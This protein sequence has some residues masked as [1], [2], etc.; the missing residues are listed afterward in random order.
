M[1]KVE[2]QNHDDISNQH[3]Q[4]PYQEYDKYTY[5]LVH[6]DVIGCHGIQY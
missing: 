4:V 6:R 1:A 2:D 3:L 5:L